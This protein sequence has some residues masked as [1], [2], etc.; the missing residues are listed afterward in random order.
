MHRALCDP[1]E[2]RLDSSVTYINALADKLPECDV[3][4]RTVRLEDVTHAD[5]CVVY[6]AQASCRAAID[7]MNAHTD[8]LLEKRKRISYMHKGAIAMN[9]EDLVNG[10]VCHSA[11]EAHNRENRE[12]DKESKHCVTCDSNHEKIVVYVNDVPDPTALYSVTA[13]GIPDWYV[14][15]QNYSPLPRRPR[16]ACTT[17]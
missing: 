15:S 1:E 6:C 2:S 11:I 14:E 4:D 13:G 5:R 10:E 16:L 17:R 8:E 3:V 9:R 12:E 7:F